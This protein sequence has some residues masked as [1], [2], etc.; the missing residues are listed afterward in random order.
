MKIDTYQDVAEKGK[1]HRDCDMVPTLILM[2]N[3]ERNAKGHNKGEK[4]RRRGQKKRRCA[5]IAKSPDDG[6]EEVVERLGCDKSHLLDNEEVKLGVNDGLLK[7]PEDGLWVLVDD[8]CVL[9][10]NSPLLLF[11]SQSSQIGHE[12]AR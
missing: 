10:A 7:T 9:L 12:I 11:H 1:Y 4:V 5:A 6:R 3:M 2:R 8:T